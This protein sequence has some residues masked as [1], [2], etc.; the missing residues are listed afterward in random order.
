MYNGRKSSRFNRRSSSFSSGS[1]VFKTGASTFEVRRHSIER[2]IE[3]EPQKSKIIPL[4]VYFP[5]EGFSAN[6]DAA[7]KITSSGT[8]YY[9]TVAV[10][11]G[12]RVNAIHLDVT[13]EP[14][15]G[16]SSQITPFYVARC[17]T[18]FHD[19]KGGNIY[20]L[21]P[22]GDTGK[23]KT[24]DEA[25]SPTESDITSTNGST[26]LPPPEL[27]LTKELFDRGDIIKHWWTGVRKN[28]M[29]G[30]QPVVYNRWE[31]VPRKCKRSNPGMFYGMMIMND[32]QAVS[33]DTDTLRVTIK[34]NFSEIPLIQ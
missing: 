20:G 29:F 7:S 21:E 26:S 6:V 10:Q 15:T 25:S 13:I 2:V 28:V 9:P 8:K 33:G 31:K 12:S 16:S 18:S 14:K 17:A 32:G 27:S 23:I 1:Q 5:D 24:S 34:E 4:M 30:G 3:I 22:D 11:E 19:V